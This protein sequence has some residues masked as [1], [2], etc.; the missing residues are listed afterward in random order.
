MN[1]AGLSQH[2]AERLLREY[3]PNEMPEPKP[4]PVWL[5]FLRQ[6]RS[7][8]IYM[9]FFAVA[10]DVGDWFYDRF[11]GWPVEGAMIAA[12]LLL[13][14]VLGTLQEVRSEEA[15]AQ[16][17]TLTAPF[18]WA[19]RGGRLVRVPGRTLVPGDLVRIE[20][21]ERL[22]ADGQLVGGGGVMTDESVLTG[23]SVPV[24][25]PVGA[26]LHSG[27]LVLRGKGAFRV[28]RTGQRSS[29]GRIATSLETIVRERTPLERRLDVLGRQIAHCIGWLAVLLIALGLLT[30]GLGRLD[31]VV[32]F[33]VALAVAAI[34]EG[35]PAVVTLTLALGVQ[36]MAKRNALVRRLAAVES[37]GSVTV[38][39]TDKTG[40]LTEN[41][42]FVREVVASDEPA[43]LTA[44]VLANDADL[45]ARVG[46]P[47]EIA[48]LEHAQARGVD[49]A[50]KHRA[51]PRRGER[52]FDSA[53][54]YMRVTVSEEG[55][56]ASYVKGAPEAVLA[57]CE[58]AP[59]ARETWSSRAAQAASGGLRVL[60]L[61]R[62]E[63]SADEGWA[64]LG[65]ATLWD[66][67]RAEVPSALREAERAG[68]R[69]LMV[70]G[71]HPATARAIAEA[72]GMHGIEVVTGAELD[73]LSEEA[74]R[75]RVREANVFA[76]VGP[77][78]KLR[79]VEVLQADGEI[80]AMTG[81]GVNDSPALKRADVG[82]AMGQRGSDVARE[83]ADLV[84]LDDDF[85]T[86]V[87]AVE[88]G[89]GIYENI[90]SF[91]RFT[92]STNVALIA[93]VVTGAAVAYAT[94]LRDTTG[95]LLVPL[96]ALQLLWINFLGDGPPALALALDRSPGLMDRPPRPPQSGLL[97]VPS[98]WFIFVT[99]AF[100]GA[101]GIALLIV[102]PVV[103]YAAAATRTM[104]FLYESVGKLVSVYPSRLAAH[105]RRIN[106][107]LHGA[108]AAGVLLQ[109]LTVVVP[110]LRTFLELSALGAPSILVL[111]LCVFTTWAVAAVTARVIH[112]PPRRECTAQTRH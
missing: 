52:P 65:L 84:L 102:L 28:S 51:H 71:D 17:R 80:V 43:A 98:K 18:A 13:N 8:L 42:M 94:G 77:D 66:P 93:L 12:V 88:E 1:I 76:R 82:V 101:L 55:R 36:R 111:A 64:W 57:R 30:E 107:V 27:T 47:L 87:G 85:A 5:R 96:T 32:M 58:L 105:R 104:L 34:P 92:F 7:P 68:V 16:L 53:W 73:G 25:K 81:D 20:A 54:Q 3:G 95:L 109:V 110:G 91:I 106:F 44:M 9:L 67:P 29:M 11:E 97:D 50:A 103:G 22:G 79:L 89:R 46:D 60:A 26:E 69:V 62:A 45:A 99:G 15:L 24:D 39:A 14:A 86:I 112:S 23:E 59:D 90:Q 78:H 49:L 83:V 56:L 63:G 40:T 31:E 4:D 74:L 72:I 61:A 33:A 41:R 100:K 70:T 48:L 6:F 35:M 75:A 108:V 10:F 2:E 21:G 38:I 19:V 37:L